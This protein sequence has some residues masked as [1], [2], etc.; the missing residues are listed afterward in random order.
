MPD[1]HTL[2]NALALDPVDQ[3]TQS[4]ERAAQ[5]FF[6]VL[7]G[8]VLA[9]VIFALFVVIA[10]VVRTRSEPRLAS[11]RTPSFGRVFAT[12]LQAGIVVLGLAVALPL[13]FPAVN[14]ATMLAG[15]GLL[16]VAAGFAFQDILSNLLAGLL[17]IFRQPFVIG[18]QIEVDGMPGTVEEINIRDTRLRSFSGRLLIIP[19]TDVYMNAIE[20]QTDG[21]VIRSDVACGVAYGTDLAHAREVALETLRSVDGIETEPAPQVFYTEFGASSIDMDLR[22]WTR[23]HQANLRAIQDQVV[24]AIHDA[25]ED[26][27][28]DIPY[29]IVTLDAGESFAEAVGGS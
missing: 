2:L 19:N 14:V 24:E 6:A 21:D 18:D 5:A 9:I 12:L 1:V 20:V 26:A 8:L 16:G 29:D 11:M 3:V 7:P 28:I 10:K 13:A 22:Y 25:F 15:L 17:L 4:V 27:G 23:S